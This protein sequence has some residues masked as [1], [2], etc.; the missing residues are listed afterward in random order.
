MRMRSYY[1]S[2]GVSIAIYVGVG[3]CPQSEP[4][5]SAQQSHWHIWAS[6]VLNHVESNPTTASRFLI[7]Q[8]EAL[9]RIDGA[10]GEAVMDWSPSQEE[11][12][13]IEQAVARLR[14]SD[15]VRGYMV[16]GDMRSFCATLLRLYHM[17]QVHG[18]VHVPVLTTSAEWRDWCSMTG[19]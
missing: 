4:R 3:C 14:H 6:G 12:A 9:E 16:T 11:A 8:L 18:E 2:T 19:P 13:Q 7:D 1:S 5:S 15:W 10:A 17:Q